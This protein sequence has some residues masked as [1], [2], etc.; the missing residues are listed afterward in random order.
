MSRR[1]AA[2]LK[3]G[4]LWLNGGICSRKCEHKR[5]LET[6]DP[7]SPELKL[8]CGNRKDM[9]AWVAWFNRSWRELRRFYGRD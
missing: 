9:A 4:C 2:C 7:L 1:K 3:G 8:P 6:G 5:E